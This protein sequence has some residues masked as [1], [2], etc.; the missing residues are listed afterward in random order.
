[1]EVTSEIRYKK[2]G[3]HVIEFIGFIL[4]AIPDS[5]FVRI[6]ILSIYFIAHYYKAQVVYRN[7]KKKCLTEMKSSMV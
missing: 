5:L 7:Y 3:F 4:P 2:F 6:G 1:M